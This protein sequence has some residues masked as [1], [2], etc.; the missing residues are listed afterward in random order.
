MRRSAVKDN[1]LVLIWLTPRSGH[2]IDDDCF[3]DFYGA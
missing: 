3:V 1:V 2:K